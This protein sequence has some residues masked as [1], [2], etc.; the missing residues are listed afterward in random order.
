MKSLSEFVSESMNKSSFEKLA[1]KLEWT[2]KSKD[3]AM[4]EKV[5]AKNWYACENGEIVAFWSPESEWIPYFYISERNRGEIN[6][7]L[8]S[9]DDSIQDPAS[10]CKNVMEKWMDYCLEQ[11]TVPELDT[12]KVPDIAED[13]AVHLMIQHFH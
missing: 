4:N 6:W 3:Y 11:A 13:Y 9:N 8:V 12:I 10:F 5:S 2:F 1:G 7:A